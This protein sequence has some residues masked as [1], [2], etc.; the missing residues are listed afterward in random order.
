M[1]RRGLGG[2]S[3]SGQRRRLAFAIDESY[4]GTSAFT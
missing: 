1:R 3:P 4:S 2:F